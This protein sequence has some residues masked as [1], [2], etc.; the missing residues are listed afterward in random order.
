MSTQPTFTFRWLSP[1][2]ISVT[3][4]LAYGTLNVLVGLVI[5]FLSRRT[6]T[7]GFATQP[8][9][10]LM[11]MLWLAFGVFQLGV[12]WFGLRQGQTWA[13][14]V[15]ALACLAQLVGWIAYGVQTRDWGAPLFWLDAII[16]LPAT[17]LGWI[18]L[19]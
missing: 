1:L 11:T 4:F 18:G 14:W 17:A 3:L 15:L 19:R 8:S 2:G 13:L 6:G 9:L 10:D 16:I 7:A 12:A 5:P